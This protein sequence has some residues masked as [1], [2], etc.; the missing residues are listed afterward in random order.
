MR[1]REFANEFTTV[2]SFFP[3]AT[4]LLEVLCVIV[5]V[6]QEC[7][8]LRVF[9]FSS[10]APERSAAEIAVAAQQQEAG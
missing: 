9:K 2:P 5:V 3:W 7:F 4:S 10:V 1:S 8:D 6:V